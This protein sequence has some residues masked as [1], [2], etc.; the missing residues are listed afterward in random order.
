MKKIGLTLG[1]FDLTHIGHIN[2]FN[3]IKKKC[4]YLIVGVHN[5]IYNIKKKKFI[6]SLSQ[7]KKMI[8]H[9]RNVDKVIIYTRADKIIK[10]IKFNI[11]FYGEDQNNKYFIKAKQICIKRKIKCIKINRTKKISSSLIAS[12]IKKSNYHNP[13]LTK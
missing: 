12:K 1:V 7:R 10:K 8:K 2:L 11:F 4:D 6:Y 5:D 3:K 9:L 13:E